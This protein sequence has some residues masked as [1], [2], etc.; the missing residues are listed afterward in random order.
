MPPGNYVATIES[1]TSW[2]RSLV[3][4]VRI[5]FKWWIE[6]KGQPLKVRVAGGDAPNTNPQSWSKIFEMVELPLDTT[7]I[8]I[9][10]CSKT[11][12]LAVSLG[13]S[14]SVFCYSL[15]V[16]PTSKQTFHDFDH[17]VDINVPIVVQ[18]LKVCENYYVCMSDI[19]VHVFKIVG[20][21]NEDKQKEEP[22]PPLEEDLPDSEL[23]DEHFVEWRFESCT[24]SGY[25]DKRWE[26]HLKSKLHPKSFPISIHL[27]AIDK[28]NEKFSSK[29]E[30]EICGP[31]LTVRGCTVDVRLDPKVFEM[32]PSF[33]ANLNAVT[34][35]FRQF[36]SKEDS[37]SLTGLQ[38]VPLYLIGMY[39]MSFNYQLIK[40]YR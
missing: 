35:L 16:D 11:S 28:E 3:T 22:L 36:V 10:C 34:L 18:D 38:L 1:K 5:Y 19:A 33:S 13:N 25:S 15:K 9:S 32:F 39:I 7:A 30:C 31:V 2:H 24:S 8:C 27:P 37:I 12:S 4:Y 20:E 40:N 14:I 29:E 23:Y 21:K 26:E 6:V 17:F